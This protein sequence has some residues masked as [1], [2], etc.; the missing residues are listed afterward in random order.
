M[1]K[2]KGNL[3]K[4][5]EMYGADLHHSLTHFVKQFDEES[6]KAE[7]IFRNLFRSSSG[8]KDPI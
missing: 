4:K 6:I 2:K 3:R 1:S 7:W 5:K 8:M